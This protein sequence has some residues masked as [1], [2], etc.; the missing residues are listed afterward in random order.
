V[1]TRG[2]RRFFSDTNIYV[3]FVR[4]LE[5]VN[6]HPW[7]DAPT[8]KDGRKMTTNCPKILEL[9]KRTQKSAQKRVLGWLFPSANIVLKRPYFFR[10]IAAKNARRLP[11]NICKTMYKNWYVVQVLS[12]YVDIRPCLFQVSV[13]LLL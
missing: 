6:C 7:L 13:Q 12:L 10:V 9:A 4:G 8:N 5:I 11:A 1:R 2:I 3:E